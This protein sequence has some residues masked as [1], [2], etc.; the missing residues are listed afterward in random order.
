MTKIV[1]FFASLMGN[2]FLVRTGIAKFLS[3]FLRLFFSC[4]I[5]PGATFGRN[6]TL[7]YGGLGIIIHGSSIIGDD[8]SIGAHVTLGGNFGRGGVPT[9]GD[10]VHIG[11]GAKILGPVIIGD[12]AVIGANA[13]VVFNVSAGSI[14]GGVPAR[15]IVRKAQS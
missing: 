2:S 10:R 4:Q 9:I 7:A 5:S 11:P 1:G 13:V 15:P 8:V 6:P 14:V 12:D 3:L